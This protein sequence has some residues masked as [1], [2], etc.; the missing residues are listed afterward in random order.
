MTKVLVCIKCDG[1]WKHTNPWRRNESVGS[2]AVC[3]ICKKPSAAIVVE[4]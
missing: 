4:K 3:P 1:E 2:P